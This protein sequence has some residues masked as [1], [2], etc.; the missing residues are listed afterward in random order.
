MAS[1]CGRRFRSKA[2]SSSSSTQAG[3]VT[4]SVGSS[5]PPSCARHRQLDRDMC[6]AQIVRSHRIPSEKFTPAPT[7]F[8]ALGRVTALTITS[9][10]ASAAVL[11]QPAGC[12][13][14]CTMPRRLLPR[15]HAAVLGRRRGGA[16]GADDADGWCW[17]RSVLAPR[18]AVVV[19]LAAAVEQCS[20]TRRRL[21]RPGRGAMD[22]SYI[23][24]TDCWSKDGLLVECALRDEAV[25]IYMYVKGFRRMSERDDDLCLRTSAQ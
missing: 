24:W 19:A 7:S 6:D 1:G 4:S 10:E 2:R 21:A 3:S 5:M 20:S 15:P 13:A 18:V 11:A 17:Y 8:R 25:H 12:R 9:S 23:T 14:L 16:I 22:L